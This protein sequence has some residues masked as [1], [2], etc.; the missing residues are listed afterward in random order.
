M[1]GGSAHT[2]ARGGYVLALAAVALTAATQ[3][4]GCSCSADA[5]RESA[6]CEEMFH[7]IGFGLRR[8]GVRKTG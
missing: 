3:A 8:S 2:I 5:G 6:R 7:D 1:K 4:P